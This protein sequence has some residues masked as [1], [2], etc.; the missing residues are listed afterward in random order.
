MAVLADAHHENG[1]DRTSI[2][3]NLIC[4]CGHP[5]DEGLVTNSP[6]LVPGSSERYQCHNR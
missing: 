3:R 1:E 5:L 4:L 6:W 2:D